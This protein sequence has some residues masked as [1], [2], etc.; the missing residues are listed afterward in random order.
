MDMQ[1]QI[2]G[3]M[4]LAVLPVVAWGQDNTVKGLQSD[5]AKQLTIDDTS[6]KTW[7]T[8]GIFSLNASQGAL[9]HWAAGGDKSSFA[10]NGLF[11]A[12]ASYIKGKNQWDNLL[13]I[14]Y[15][16]LKTNSTGFRKS[17][18][19]F[20][21]T[22]KYG[23]QASKKWYY[24]ALLDFK[25]QFSNGYQYTDSGRIFNS[26]LLSPAYLLLS[27]GMD[28]KAT[29]YFDLYLSPITS[30]WT[31]VSNDELA[32]KGNFGL[33]PGDH[34][35]N[36]IGAFVSANFAKDLSPS[37]NFKSRLDL[38]SNYQHN[39]QNVDVNFTNL[40]TMKITKDLATTL[41][42][43]MIYDDDVKFP[44]EDGSREVAHLQ[45]KEILGLGFSYKF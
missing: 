32:A 44:T 9:S 4:A 34:V 27:L 11:S 15:G 23:R 8:G 18:D 6:H 37:I 3:L 24:T 7:R 17:D 12:Y 43:D 39:P 41:S 20:Y 28:Y 5:A 26:A 25:T 19:H 22:S 38:F 42:V 36:E 35:R 40:L 30:R 1:R 29:D 33:D 2:F 13:D 31:I 45:L 21:F 16:Y 14:A 10:I